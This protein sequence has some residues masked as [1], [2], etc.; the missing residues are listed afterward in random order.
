MVNIKH[1]FE[2]I[3]DPMQT[4]LEPDVW[5]NDKINPEIRKTILGIVKKTG[6]QKYIKLLIVGSITTKF[7]STESD[8]DVTVVMNAGP[9]DELIT[10]SRELAPQINGINK[11][12]TYDINFFFQSK[13][14]LD[15]MQTLADGIYDLIENKWIK[16]APD[17]DPID[18]LLENPKKLAEHISKQLDM[19]LDDITMET[20][21]IIRNAKKPNLQN[22]N[23]KLGL[24]KMELDDYV[25]TLKDVHLRRNEE[26]SRALEND[27]LS[28][29]QKYGSRNYLPWNIIYKYL[30]KWLYY[31]WQNLFKDV[32]KDGKVDMK[33]VKEIFSQF[34]KAW[35]KNEN[36]K[37]I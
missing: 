35:E 31:K 16:K 1:I 28:V 13:D 3:I 10:T 26:F 23:N 30:V 20:N 37:S 33:E 17:L 9:D 19:K 2:S 22:I 32:A 36:K 24:L 18:D 8:I 29:V 5:P 11:F 14:Y 6:I 21:E 12:K 4:S 27:D 15:T 34:V 7:W 25:K